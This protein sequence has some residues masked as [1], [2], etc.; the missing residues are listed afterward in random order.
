[1]RAPEQRDFTSHLNASDALLWSME[2]D[3]CLRSTIVAVSLLDR[4]PDWKRLSRRIAEACE[5]I[6]RLRQHVVAT[7]LRLGPPRWQLDQYFDIDYHLRRTVAPEPGD[8]RSVL[9]IAGLMAMSAFDKDRPLWE[10][11]LVEG[12][13][14]GRAAFIH[15]VHHSITDGVGGVKLGQLLLDEK[16]N[17]APLGVKS[18]AVKTR[19]AGEQRTSGLAAI[20]ESVAADLRS[21]ATATM[22]SAQ[23]LPSVAARALTNPAA[24]VMKVTREVRSIGK[25]LAPVT[26]PLS[27]IMIHRGL[28]RRLDS[29]D[30]SLDSLMNAAHAADSTLNDAFLASVSGGMRRYHGRHDVPVDALRVTMPINMRLPGDPPGSN[31]FTPARFA[32]PVS[33]V[34]AADRMRQLGLLARNWRKEPSVKRTELVANILNRLPVFVA[35][36]ALG[37]MLKAIDFVATNV[38]GLKHRAYM[39]GGEVIREYAFAPPSGAAFSIALMSHIDQCCVGINIDTSA[40]PDPEVLTECLREG[41]DEV[42]AIGRKT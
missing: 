19:L 36:S 42:L 22:R 35:T 12:L 24:Q 38:P 34:D 27:P 21:A 31:R 11:T 2:K 39:A 40:V 15:K 14:G 20:G 28:S 5:L 18:G 9:D 16:R 10:F 17:P 26:K 1:V 3:P 13:T 6:P 29:F 30:I 4:S 37:S 7:P 23:A 41:F 8:L 33:T 25:L 32:L